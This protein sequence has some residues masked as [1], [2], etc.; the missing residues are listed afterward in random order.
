MGVCWEGWAGPGRVPR[1]GTGSSQGLAAEEGL[2]LPAHGVDAE[3][4][5]QGQ[6][7]GAHLVG[8]QVGAHQVSQGLQGTGKG[9]R[10]QIQLG[11]P[12]PAPLTHT[13]TLGCNKPLCAKHISSISAL[14]LKTRQKLPEN[15]HT[16]Q[17]TQLQTLTANQQSRYLG[18]QWISIQRLCSSDVFNSTLKQKQG[19]KS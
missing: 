1:A 13:H 12:P 17:E 19:G 18:E 15:I 10:G 4:A 3:R 9:Q 7:A 8:L 5:A 6:L 2:A 11:N 14:K 16:Q